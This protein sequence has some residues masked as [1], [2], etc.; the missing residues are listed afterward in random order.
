LGAQRSAKGQRS[1]SR[2]PGWLKLGK[3]Y[4]NHGGGSGGVV[5]NLKWIAATRDPL[6]G[7]LIGYQRAI[8]G[9]GNM[10]LAGRSRD[11][12]YRRVHDIRWGGR[13]NT[14]LDRKST[15]LNSSHVAI[16]Y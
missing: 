8:R 12:R 4:V 1:R 7:Q 2:R 5:R 10:P 6:A 16:S 14:E 9:H 15:R 13:V 3:R 11:R